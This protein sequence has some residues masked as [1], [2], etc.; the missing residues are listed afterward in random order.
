MVGKTPESLTAPW[1][2]VTELDSPQVNQPDHLVEFMIQLDCYAGATGGQPEATNLARAVR[3]VLGTLPNAGVRMLGGPR[4][5]DTDIE[6]ARD[7]KIVVALVW[8]HG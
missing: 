5:L 8:L 1:V 7:R 4:G 2:R 6:P 3:A